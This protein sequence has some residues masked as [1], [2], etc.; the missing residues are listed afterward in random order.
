M[1]VIA[2]YFD[3]RIGEFRETNLWELKCLES[4]NK[5]EF[6]YRQRR[7]FRDKSYAFPMTLV[8]RG[9]SQGFRRKAT[10]RHGLNVNFRGDNESLTHQGNKEALLL[11]RKLCIRFNGEKV[12]LFIHS[13][14]KE[15]SVVCNGSEYRI[16]LFLELERT[17]PASYYDELN[18]KL[19]FEIYHTCKVDSK[20]AEDFAIERQPL[21][22]YKVASNCIISDNIKSI[23]E[24][25]QQ[26]EKLAN[27]YA[28]QCINGYLICP[29]RLE[30]L[31][32][33]R[34]STNGNWTARFGN[35]YFTIIKSKFE[36]A[37]GIIFNQRRKPLWQYMGKKF[38]T[39][40]D[41]KKTADFIAFKLYN[42][43]QV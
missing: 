39:I 12:L 3:E 8:R 27:R 42:G 22:E 17:E 32:N 19:W 23:N 14:E 41:A 2:Y 7:L 31:S 28:T 11:L 5:E 30:T 36:E 26:V 33:W 40:D 9:K 6:L 37:Y 13:I 38:D 16:D 25:S 34:K 15:K 10:Q 4:T 24:Y 18:G 35:D 21:F 20:Q 43:E 1:Q 29:A